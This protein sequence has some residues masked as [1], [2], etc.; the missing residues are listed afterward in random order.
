MELV[1]LA[2]SAISAAG[3]MAKGSAAA[4]A[5]PSRVDGTNSL[6]FDNSGWNVT[7]GGGGRIDSTRAD[8]AASG[9]AGL[10]PYLP[11]FAIA[12]AA[13]VLWKISKK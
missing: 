9:G 8:G 10:S 4:P 5:G 12:V 11:Y 13:I 7:T 6:L 2:A 1:P 3:N